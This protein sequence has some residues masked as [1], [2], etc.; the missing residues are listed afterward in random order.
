VTPDV[1]TSGDGYT[2][3]V[4]STVAWLVVLAL[5]VHPWPLN[6]RGLL[7]VLCIAT[8]A[9]PPGQPL[10]LGPEV[11]SALDDNRVGHEEVPQGKAPVELD[12]AGLEDLLRRFGGR[13]AEIARHVG[14][15][16]PRIYRMLWS[17]GLEPDRFRGR[18]SPEIPRQ[19]LLHDELRRDQI[20]LQEGHERIVDLRDLAPVG[21][22]TLDPLDGPARRAAGAWTGAYGNSR[23]PQRLVAPGPWRHDGMK[24]Q[25]IERGG[26]TM[27]SGKTDELKGRVKE[28]AGALTGDEKLKREGKTDQAVGKIK[29][30][31]EKVIEKV[32]DTIKS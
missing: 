25:D 32:K 14:V 1:T 7:N 15:S 21:Y 27:A 26:T 16:R 9:T 8:I 29:Q 24:Q 19:G 11:Q 17:E 3:S 10:G 12:R 5:L 13:V 18:P 30:Q 20:E 2:H 6:V 23:R 28:A 31:A 22:L 4:K